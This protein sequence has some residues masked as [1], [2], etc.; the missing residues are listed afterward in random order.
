MLFMR[1][2]LLLALVL[3]GWTTHASAANWSFWRGPEQNGVSRERDLPDR[4]S[5]NRKAK[6]NNLI[7][8]APYGSIAT[9]IV[10]DGQV[11]M[12]GKTG[13]GETL[14]ERVMAIDADT[15]ELKWQHK[16]NVWLTDIVEDRLGWGHM[17]GDP[18]TGNVY[19]H[20][21]AGQFICFDKTGK[22]VWQHSMTEEYARLTGY[23]GRVTSPIVD[24]DKVILSMVN[25]SWGELTVGNTRMVAFDKKT[26]K[27]I[28]WGSGQYRVKD[29]YYSTPVVAVIG[30]QRLILTGG[31]DGCIHAFKVRTGEKVWSYKFED[32]GGAI[33]CSPVVQGNKIWIGHGEEN[34][35]NGTQG[36][37]ICLDGSVVEKGK[38]KLLWKHDGIKVKFASPL[39]HD[40]LLYVCDDAGKLYC[41]DPDKG[42]EIWHYQYG[43]NTKGSPVW[44]DGK[45]YISEVD[46]KFHILK[47]NGRK[48]PTT[49]SPAY[50]FRGKGVVPV[51]LHGSAAVV[52]GRVYFT[53]TEQLIC[54]GKKDHK[55]ESD[56]IPAPVKEGPAG[57]KA[58]HLQVIPADVML[59]PGESVHFKLVAYDGMGR[60]LGEQVFLGSSASFSWERAGMLPP[61]YPVNMKGPPPGKP[62]PPLL[63]SLEEGSAGILKGMSAQFTAAKAP[64]GQFG[65]VVAKWGKLA[66]YA[67]VRVVPVLPYTNDF[68]KVPE[69]KTPAGWVNTMGKF[70]VVVGPDGKNV[71][72]KRNDNAAPPV[73]RIHAYIGAPETK[74]YTIETEVYGT[75][76]RDKDMPD[77]GIGAC[78]YGLYM[79]GNDQELRLVTWDAQKRL[80]KK[81]PF[82]WKPK[83]WYRMKLTASVVDGKGIVKGK[84]WPRGE[85]EPEKWTIEIE[86]PVPNTEGAP[87]IYGFPNGVINAENPGPEIYYS[88]VKI[89]PNKK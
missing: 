33:N 50:R 31:G 65:R 85:S 5:L 22:I 13:E 30:G 25:G 14:Q 11:Y 86:D 73:A 64:N 10:Q 24:E 35:G 36:R 53:T 87:L 75:K 2:N 17:V 47:D 76:I 62:G 68:S 4:W 3:L 7:F 20:M 39:L 43:T 70:S 18:E 44:A 79:I 72:R 6:D 82:A 67:R 56:K 45:F 80:Q 89:T 74:D 81:L 37:I 29:T 16:V 1:H 55:A 61:V 41:F 69:G 51:E 60:R 15:G 57:E 27:V 9:P 19:A 21:S 8:A 23:G 54:I 38:P 83:T 63:G 84:V 28:W 71:L 42:E 88:Y 58:E 48:P 26:G 52:N 12:M 78:R 46:R 66:G 49:A 34:E 32:G 40:N 59:K 77:I